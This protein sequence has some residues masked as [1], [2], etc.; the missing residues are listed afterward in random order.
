MPGTDV[1]L[2][3]EPSMS[4]QN[5]KFRASV[6]QL[7]SKLILAKKVVK[8]DLCLD[9]YDALAFDAD[10]AINALRSINQCAT[11]IVP[12]KQTY[13][14]T[15]ATRAR[16]GI[17]AC[18]CAFRK[19]K[20]LDNNPFE[21]ILAQLRGLIDEVIPIE[22]EGDNEHESTVGTEIVSLSDDGAK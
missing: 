14:D 16:T 10:S 5:D 7:V 13:G 15:F 17:R 18:V 2:F 1:S 12:L 3:E 20:G 9:N 4:E 22:G 6:Q 19:G 21:A 11:V 8:P